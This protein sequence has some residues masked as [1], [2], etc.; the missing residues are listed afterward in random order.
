MVTPGSVAA[1]GPPATASPPAAESPGADPA[2]DDCPDVRCVSVAV[3]GDV[4]LHEPLWE[5]AARD[6]AGGGLDFGPLLAG[7]APYLAEADVAVCH[8]ETPLAGPG[9]EPTGYPE[10]QVPAE[11][12]DALADVGYDACSTASNHTTDHGRAGVVATLDALDAAGLQH[13][14]SARDATPRPTPR[15]SSPLRAVRW[16]WLRR[17]TA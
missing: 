9:V 11:I 17:P 7:Q 15:R 4:L 12:A 6:G 2:P 14:G 3:T 10:F 13:A 16:V 5:Q 8:L 1:G